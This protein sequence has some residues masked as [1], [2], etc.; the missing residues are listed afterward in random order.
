M[1]HPVSADEGI[2]ILDLAGCALREK[3]ENYQEKGRSS[4][5]KGG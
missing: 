1:P 3:C 5:N 4:H 2:D